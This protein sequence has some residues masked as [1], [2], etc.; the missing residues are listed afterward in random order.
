MKEP[1]FPTCGDCQRY[2]SASR[3]VL[4]EVVE[5]GNPSGSVLVI[6]G[7][8]PGRQEEEQGRPWVGPS[9]RYVRSFIETFSRVFSRIYLTNACLCRADKPPTK[10]EIEAC[11]PNLEK[12]LSE[13][14]SD[15][16]LMACGRIAESALKGRD[17]VYVPHPSSF[18]R[19]GQSIQRWVVG[20]RSKLRITQE[21]P[22]FPISEYNGEPITSSTVSVDAE[23]TDIRNPF[24]ISVFDGERCY[25]FPPSK[26][27]ALPH[28]LSEKTI[29]AHNAVV[30]GYILHSLG[31]DVGDVTFVDTLS[32][33]RAYDDS[34]SSDLKSLA[35]YA[36]GLVYSSPK[37]LRK[38]EITRDVIL[39]NAR[40]A[41]V[42]YR[43]FRVLS[44]LRDYT[45]LRH[46]LLD[47]LIPTLVRMGARGIR[48]D[49]DEVSRLMKEIKS[50]RDATFRELKDAKDINWDSPVQVKSFFEGLGYKTDSV[51]KTFLQGVDHPVARKLLEYRKYSKL[52]STFLKPL[53]EV[54]RC[55]FLLNPSGT[56]TGRL[57]FLD[58]VVNV[59]TIPDEL[60]SC[61][62]PDPGYVWVKADFKTHEVRVLAWLAETPVWRDNVADWSKEPTPIHDLLKKGDP[63][64]QLSY[65]Y[66][67]VDDPKLRRDLTKMTFLALMYGAGPKRIYEQA[68]KMGAFA[69]FDKVK[70][71]VEELKRKLVSIERLRNFVENRSKYLGTH[72][73]PILTWPPLWRARR[74]DLRGAD[75]KAMDEYRKALINTPVQGAAADICTMAAL[76]ISN[77]Y[78]LLNIVHDEIDVQVPEED[79]VSAKD[80]IKRCMTVFWTLRLPSGFSLPVIPNLEVEIKEGRSWAL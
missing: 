55:W 29:I 73:T 66:D 60:R 63:Y 43:L 46:A 52:I 22:E 25:Y 70:Q 64:D 69:P 53:Q 80:Y 65:L 38:G 57:S 10:A 14:G 1:P 47:G 42:C 79:L 30:E 44:N 41:Y 13:A 31:L 40:D 51:D 54:E 5:G 21:F 16:Q 67:F 68:V 34:M 35:A 74:F 59:Q 75:F 78:D 58:G 45:V 56:E 32:M 8:D 48:I 50:K 36:F 27:H 11:R 77:I 61:F 19:V 26:F 3:C 6:V 24:L 76:M 18:L 33:S 28:I 37:E 39:Y 9:G 62:V 72:H 2:K 15:A 23:F 4:P 17:Y 20:A 71:V 12:V 49:Q 7:Q